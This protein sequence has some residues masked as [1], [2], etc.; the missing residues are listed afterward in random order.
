MAEAESKQGLKTEP[1]VSEEHVQKMIEFLNH[2]TS[3]RV[4]T[5]DEFDKLSSE[6][7]VSF[8]HSTPIKGTT[9]H[10]KPPL[11]PVRS[12]SIAR[13]A[14]YAAGFGNNTTVSCSNSSYAKPKIPCIRGSLKG[15]ARGLLLSLPDG[16]TPTQIIEKLDGIYG[17][18]FSSEAL[19]QKFYMETQKQGQSVADYGMRLEDIAQKA[20]EKGQIS[21]QAKN[22]MLRSKLWSGL[23]DPLLK[24]ASRYKYDTV[25][26]FDQL[27]KE[28]RSIELDLSNYASGSDNKIQHQPAVVEQSGMQEMIKSMKLLNT[29]MESFEGELKK[30]KE[31]KPDDHTS[32]SNSQFRGQG[33]G[34]Y[35]GSDRRGRF[36]NNRGWRGRGYTGNQ[37]NQNYNS[38]TRGLNG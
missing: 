33:R 3:F 27:L 19:L 5:S 8:G 23:R 28:I 1:K 29:R 12:S 32:S 25:E 26:K 16:A 34:N 6:K 21:S 36:N 37:Q 18:V 35:R 17:N 22:D 14:T 7:H 11:A 13:V 38:Q 31:S 20:V 30:L 4:V 9:A 15:K 10:T 24:N 2:N